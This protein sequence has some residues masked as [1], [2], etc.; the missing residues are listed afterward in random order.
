MMRWCRVARV[1]RRLPWPSA[2]VWTCMRENISTCA[3]SRS[4]ICRLSLTVSGRTIFGSERVSRS[5]NRISV[6]SPRVSKG[7]SRRMPSLTVGLLTL[8]VLRH[9]D[10]LRREFW[11]DAFVF[12][13]EKDKGV[14]PFLILNPLQPFS[15]IAFLIS[16]PAQTQVSPTRGADDFG[17]RFLVSIGNDQGT[18]L[19]AQ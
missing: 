2:V 16:S 7:N 17:Q 5:S 14:F 8:T 15:E 13:F 3:R 10:K 19:L 12:M 6:R 9:L 11:P 1:T 4:I 18:I